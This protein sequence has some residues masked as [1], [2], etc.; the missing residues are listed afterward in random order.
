MY[1]YH[2]SKKM[3][4]R[5]TYSTKTFFGNV[6]WGC[7]RPWTTEIPSLMPVCCLLKTRYMKSNFMS[8][9]FYTV[10]PSNSRLTRSKPWL[11]HQ[12]LSIK[13][14]SWLIVPADVFFWLN[15]FLFQISNH[16]P[17]LRKSL[18]NHFPVMSFGFL[19]V[20]SD[21]G[22][23]LRAASGPLCIQGPFSHRLPAKLIM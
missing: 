2:A 6:N 11:I 1:I 23:I 13:G 7:K 16:C 5:T 4:R 8:Y 9:C 10:I 15:K 12:N 22:L 17:N 14:A 3:V 18:H 19:G 20:L 21:R